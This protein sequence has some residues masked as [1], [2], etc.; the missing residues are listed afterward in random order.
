MADKF[1]GFQGTVDEVQWA[2]LMAGIGQKYTLVAGDPVRASGRVVSI[3]PRAQIGCGVLYEH[4]AV[5]TVTVP[6]PATGQWHLLVA[7]RVWSSRTASYVLVAGNVTADAAQTAPPATLPAARNKTVGL[8]DDEPIA[9]VHARASVTTL[10]LWQMSVKRDGRVP[11]LWALFDPNEQGIYRAYS[12]TDGAEY[13]WSGSAWRPGVS[14]S[15][16]SVY[17]L[18]RA[19]TTATTAMTWDIPNAPLNKGGYLNPAQNTRIIAPVKGI[20]RV[21][22][23]IRQNGV[24]TSTSLLY[25]NGVI[26]NPGG[27]DNGA[28]GVAG[29]AVTLG[30]GGVYSLNAGD[31]LEVYVVSTAATAGTVWT[32]GSTF[33]LELIEAL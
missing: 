7:R 6:T 18:Q 25:R 17:G 21:A 16:V 13:S 28:S 12:E 22:Y 5:K 23:N 26:I 10:S 31:Y 14:K 20:Y 33:S 1:V 30:G 27:L 24:T 32:S 19:I 2:A 29:A 8:T 9:W 4:D 15:Y 11:G 3:D